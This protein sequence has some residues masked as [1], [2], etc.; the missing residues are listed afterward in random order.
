MTF[1]AGKNSTPS[2]IKYSHPRL[3][4]HVGHIDFFSY[5]SAAQPSDL[6]NLKMFTIDI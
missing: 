3:A 5:L 2:F 4:Q 6:Q 1:Q